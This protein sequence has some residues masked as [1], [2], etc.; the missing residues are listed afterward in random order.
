M[1]QPATIWDCVSGGPQFISMFVGGTSRTL[2]LPPQANCP[3]DK[4]DLDTLKNDSFD[5]GRIG[6]EC[7][8]ESGGVS[9][10]RVAYGIENQSHFKSIQLDQAEFSETNE[11][12]QVIDKLANAGD[13]S[14]RAL[15]GQNLHNVYLTRSYNCTVEAM[16]NMMISPLMYF[17]LTNVPMFHGTYIIK[18]VS[19]KVSPHSVAT[20]FMGTRQPIATVPVIKEIAS[21]LSVAISSADVVEDGRTVEEILGGKKS[22]GGSSQGSNSEDGDTSVGGGSAT[23][24]EPWKLTYSYGKTSKGTLFSKQDGGSLPINAGTC[25]VLINKTRPSGGNNGWVIWEYYDALVALDESFKTT[26]G[27][28]APPTG[29]GYRT[30]ES[31]IAARIVNKCPACGSKSMNSGGENSVCYKEGYVVYK[32]GLGVG[33]LDKDQLKLSSSECGTPTASVKWNASNQKFYSSSNHGFGSAIDMKSP[34]Q[35]GRG[36][37][38]FNEDANYGLTTAR[39][40]VFDSDKEFLKSDGYIDIAKVKDRWKSN[41]S[42]IVKNSKFDEALYYIWLRKNAPLFG[43]SLIN[44][45][46]WHFN[47]IIGPPGSKT[48][49]I[50]GW[51]SPSNTTNGTGVGATINSHTTLL[52]NVGHSDFFLVIEASIKTTLLYSVL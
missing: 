50:Q 26:F 5:L 38:Y 22:N 24:I 11:S 18:E 27:F 35:I 47:Y 42:G 49:Q 44:S 8:K 20:T 17:E 1:F 51:N 15:K 21:A 31:Q 36:T 43:L 9:A 10:F 34:K 41:G 23:C 37:F 46:A 13:P 6:E 14:N 39:K 32:D 33:K 3:I 25:Q 12:L 19:H 30:T 45:E 29:G 40:R 7:P 16:G 52:L 28:Y 48:N 4:N 2:D